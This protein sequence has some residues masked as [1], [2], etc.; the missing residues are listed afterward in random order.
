MGQYTCCNNDTRDPQ[1]NVNTVPDA[2]LPTQIMR[3]SLHKSLNEEP[4]LAK[5]GTDTESIS[6]ADNLN[7][8][9]MDIAY[10]LPYEVLLETEAGPDL[11]HLRVYRWE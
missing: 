8:Y 10:V 7:Q 11:V 6:A 4:A 1:T 5:S 9:E 2:N 3:V